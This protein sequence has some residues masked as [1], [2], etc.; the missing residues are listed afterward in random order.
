MLYS[1]LLHEA[2]QICER[3]RKF[4][5]QRVYLSSYFRRETCFIGKKATQVSR[6]DD[7]AG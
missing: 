4:E 6:L 2:G 3:I 1:P 7:A 5:K